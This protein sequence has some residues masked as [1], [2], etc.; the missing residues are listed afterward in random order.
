MALLQQRRD[1]TAYAVRAVVESHDPVASVYFGLLERDVRGEEIDRGTR[2]HTLAATLL[3][4]GAGHAVVDVMTPSS[5]IA[6]A[7]R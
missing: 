1:V 3:D 7:F 6:R 4:Q 5:P 2:W